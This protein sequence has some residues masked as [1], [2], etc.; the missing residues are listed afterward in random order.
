MGTREL[1]KFTD[2]LKNKIFKM[3]K[4]FLKIFYAGRHEYGPVFTAP[5]ENTY[6]TTLNITTKLSYVQIFM[7][8]VPI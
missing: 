4:K 6:D 8:G 5:P 1:Q 2:A 3:H 7:I